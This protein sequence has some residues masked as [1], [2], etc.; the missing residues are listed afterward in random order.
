MMEP[1]PT[2]QVKESSGSQ[3]D[4]FYSHRR[5]INLI[6]RDLE[7]V[8]G[9]EEVNIICH[10]VEREEGVAEDPDQ[11]AKLIPSLL[12]HELQDGV[13]LADELAQPHDLAGPLEMH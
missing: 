1:E 8:E 10:P 13:I 9:A 11:P 5:L 4:E 3:G 12:F 6:F 7:H 2:P